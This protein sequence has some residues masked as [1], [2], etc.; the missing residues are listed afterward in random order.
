[1]R[2]LFAFLLGDFQRDFRVDV[3]AIFA[4]RVRQLWLSALFADRIVHCFQPMVAAT[5][6]CPAFTGFLYW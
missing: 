1:M 4:R 5:R 3:T 6:P 2:I